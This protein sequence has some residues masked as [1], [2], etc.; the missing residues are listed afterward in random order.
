MIKDYNQ[1]ELIEFE[2][3]I[4]TEFNSSKIKAPIHLY[5]GNEQQMIDIFKIF[6][7]TIG[8]FVHGDHTINV[9]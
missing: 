3:D 1:Y 9:Y 2:E 4:A 5:N 6:N 8:Y 7:K